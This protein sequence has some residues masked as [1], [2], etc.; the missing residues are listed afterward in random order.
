MR[1]NSH[2]S[3][4]AAESEPRPL[5]RST[6]PSATTSNTATASTTTP[7]V[8]TSI[9]AP[10]SSATPATSAH[11]RRP[12]NFLAHP[13]PKKMSLIHTVEPPPR[14]LSF[15]LT[16]STSTSTSLSTSPSNRLSSVSPAPSNRPPSMSAAPSNLSSNPHR[17][18]TAAL[19]KFSRSVDHLADIL[20]SSDDDDGAGALVSTS[21]PAPASVFASVPASVPA[22]ILASVSA[23]TSVARRASES[24]VSSITATTATSKSGSISSRQSRGNL[25]DDSDPEPVA[26]SSGET[27]ASGSGHKR[28]GS[29]SSVRSKSSIRSRRERENEIRAQY[30]YYNLNPKDLPDVSAEMERWYA[31]TDR[32]GFMS[33]ERQTLQVSDKTAAEREASRSQKWARMARKIFLGDEE[34]YTFMR[35]PKLSQSNNLPPPPQNSSSRGFTRVSRTHGGARHGMFLQW[36]KIRTCRVSYS[37]LLT[38]ILSRTTPPENI[39][40]YYMITNSLSEAEFDNNLRRTYNDLLRVSSPHERQIDLDIPRTMH[41]HIMFRT[42]FGFGW[43]SCASAASHLEFHGLVWSG[44]KRAQRILFNV[45]RAFS[46]Y[47]KEVGYCQGMTN[48]AATLLMFFEEEVSQKT[49]IILTHLFRRYNLH[50]LFIPGF[51]ALIESFYIQEQLMQKYAP[52]VAKAFGSSVAYPLSS[53]QSKLQITSSAYATRWFITLFTGGVVPYHTLLRIWDLF[54]LM[55]FDAL[56]YVA[57][58]LLKEN[59]DNLI[60]SDF[61][62]VMNALS[63][64]MQVRNDDRFMRSVRRLCERGQADGLVDQYRRQYRVR[65]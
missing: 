26:S 18:S 25:G 37:R 20:N 33:E 7:S 60:S 34:V 56:Y 19:E 16:P 4:S 39:R 23:S 28:S 45:L 47:D 1:A 10:S 54:F 52:R 30:E 44:F 48:V 36:F 63:S 12:H 8:A 46:S 11:S 59:Q 55:G 51:P 50:N 57:V 15:P 2:P 31:M 13:P 40:R 49:F 3:A 42:R 9:A 65:T 64:T 21:A 5:R 41:G 53:K 35:S 27:N 58:A 24:A 61:E 43:V 14:T 6:A 29:K 17:A 32:Y 38:F 62:K 22:S